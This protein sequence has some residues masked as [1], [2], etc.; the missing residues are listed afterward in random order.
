MNYPI[1]KGKS[2]LW[3]NKSKHNEIERSGIKFEYVEV[4]DKRGKIATT[5]N[6]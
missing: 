2:W 3:H 5:K 1:I 4:T 6:V